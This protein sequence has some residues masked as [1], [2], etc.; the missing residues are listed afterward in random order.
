MTG[1]HDGPFGPYPATGSKLARP[2]CE[3][4]R[5]DSSG[6]AVRCDYFYDTTTA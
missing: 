4:M 3:V 1:V 2:W 6:R 5:Y